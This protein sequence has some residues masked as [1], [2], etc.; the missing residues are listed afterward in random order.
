MSHEQINPFDNDN[1]LF[2]V[3]INSEEQYSLWPVLR[4][5]PAGW[6]VVFGPESK[7]ACEQYVE[8]HWLDIRC[9]SARQALA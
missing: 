7:M 8:Q 1:Y 4:A 3:L 2:L 6:T 9:R 5:V